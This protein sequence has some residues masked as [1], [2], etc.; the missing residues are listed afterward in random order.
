MEEYFRRIELIKN[1]FIFSIFFLFFL[2]FW[3]VVLP[4]ALDIVLFVNERFG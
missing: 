4:S 3:E 1:L 2:S